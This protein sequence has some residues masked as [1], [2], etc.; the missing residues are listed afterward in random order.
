MCMQ[1]QRAADSM[2]ANGNVQ[3]RLWQ[4]AGA[5]LR[6]FH[7]PQGDCF[8]I[9]AEEFQ[10]PR[11][12]DARSLP[13]EESGYLSQTPCFVTLGANPRLNKKEETL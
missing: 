11:I 1:L 6:P 10:F 4:N 7:Q 3:V 13:A 2:R 9:D 12:A 8:V 5:A